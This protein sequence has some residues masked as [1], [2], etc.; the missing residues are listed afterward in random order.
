M[1]ARFRVRFKS[2]IEQYELRELHFHSQMRTK[3]LEVQYHLARHEREKKNAENESA[4]A[5]HLQAQVQAF[6]KTE[7][8]LRN[9]LNV[10]V[11][12]FKQVSSPSFPSKDSQGASRLATAHSGRRPRELTGATTKSL[13][14]QVEDTLNNSNDLFL[15]FRKEMEDMSKKCKRLEKEN[16]SLKRQKEATAANIIRMAD[17]RQDWK[18]KLE[19]AEKK[20]EKL[21]SIIQQ[22]QQQGRKLPPENSTTMDYSASNKGA[23]EEDESDYSNHGD[24]GRLV[25]IQV[26]GREGGSHQSAEQPARYSNYKSEH[27]P[28]AR[29]AA[30]NGH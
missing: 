13:R 14:S 7:T 25:G 18:K 9:Q 26:G 4:R 15:S 17:E 6:T 27:Q 24:D 3:E 30:T 8:E 12:K 19:M 1:L 10:Y 16:E 21:M 22:M 28:L 11:D 5:R 2:L 20:S 29:Q 23:A